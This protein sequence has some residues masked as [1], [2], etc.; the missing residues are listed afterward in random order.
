MS[1]QQQPAIVVQS[2]SA[3]MP[4]VHCQTASVQVAC[5]IAKQMHLQEQNARLQ[6]PNGLS[7][8]FYAFLDVPVLAFHATSQAAIRY[9]IHA[10]HATLTNKYKQMNYALN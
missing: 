10:R 4:S 1:Y 5:L 2:Q 6:D 7:V 9:H 8:S 3:P